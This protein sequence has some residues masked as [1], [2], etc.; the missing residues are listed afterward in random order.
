[1]S[2]EEDVTPTYSA[3]YGRT[4]LLAILYTFCAISAVVG[5]LQ[6]ASG[7][8][9][10]FVP[11]VRFGLTVVLAYFVFRGSI[12]ARVLLAF[13]S[14]IA[15]LFGLYYAVELLTKLDVEAAAIFAILAGFY[16]LAAWAIFQS[17]H[18]QAYWA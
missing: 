9:A 14:V 17:P 10:P 18:I 16:T 7:S 5:L 2:D 8:K 3:A 13:L 15:A 6:I 4:Q 12:G 11:V 1:M